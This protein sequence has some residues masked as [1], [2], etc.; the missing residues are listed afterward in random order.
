M[1][2][3]RTVLRHAIVFLVLFFLP[4]R[5]APLPLEWYWHHRAFLGALLLW[6]LLSGWAGFAAVIRGFWIEAFE[7]LSDRAGGPAWLYDLLRKWGGCPRCVAF[8]TA[9]LPVLIAGLLYWQFGVVFWMN[10]LVAL[11]FATCAA[12]LGAALATGLQLTALLARDG[13]D[14]ADDGPHSK[15]D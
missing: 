13:D 14:E 12:S 7:G 11:Y 10:W 2:G 4:A 15:N 6:G 8:W 3:H 1:Y 9:G 5:L